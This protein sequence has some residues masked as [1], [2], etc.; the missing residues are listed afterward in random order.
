MTDAKQLT[1][2]LYDALV[3]AEITFWDCGD[4]SATP[5]ET[6]TN[7][8]DDPAA[9]V[10]IDDTVSLATIAAF[11]VKRGWSSFWVRCG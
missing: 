8:L 7:T 10:I 6:R 5:K 3:E 2:D 9:E 1:A 4:S 11:L